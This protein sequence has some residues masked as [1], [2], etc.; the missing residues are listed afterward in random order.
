MILLW[1]AV[2]YQALWIHVGPA[3]SITS[4]KK[5]SRILVAKPVAAASVW[6]AVHTYAGRVMGPVKFMEPII[7]ANFRYRADF[8]ISR[9]CMQFPGQP[10][11]IAIVCQYS[12]NKASLT[13]NDLPVSPTTCCTRITPRHER[14]PTG[15]TDRTLAECLL[16]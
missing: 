14:G 2:L 3:E 1:H 10:A 6:I 13:R 4:V 5:P 15:R 8:G 7:N 11:I 16:K 12:R 9:R